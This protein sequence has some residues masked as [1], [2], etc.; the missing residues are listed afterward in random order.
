MKRRIALWELALAV[1]LGSIV[2][3]GFGAD[4]SGVK[5]SVISLPSGPGS[6]EGLG[7]SFEPQL[8]SG[9]SSYSV[10]LATLPGRAGFAP[11]L[12]LTYSSGGTAGVVGLGWSLSLPSL[13][14][15]TDKGMPFYV[16][17]A[18][19]T[20]DDQD[21]TVDEFDELDTIIHSSGE[22]LVPLVDGSWRNENEQEFQR[23]ERVGAGWRSLRKDGVALSFGTTAASRIERPSLGGSY[24]WL[25]DR[26]ED[27]NG[28]VISFVWSGAVDGTRQIYLDAIRYNPNDGSGMV[29]DFEYEARP[30]PISDFRPGFELFTAKRLTRIEMT[31]R[32]NAV[33]AYRLTYAPTSSTQPHSLLA[34]IATEGRD[35]VSTLP[36]AEFTYTEFDSAIG[37]P[38]PMPSAPALAL[39]TDIDLIDLDG[40][41][42]PDILDTGPAVHRYFLNLGADVSGVVAWSPQFFMAASP[43]EKLSSSYVHLADLDGDARTD[44]MRRYD[45]TQ[46][47]QVW[48][49]DAQLKWESNGF[50]TSAGFNLADPDTR[51]VDLDHDK[52]VDVVQTGAT[53]T[54]AWLALPN[55]RYSNPF[56][57]AAGSPALRFSS[58]T[59]HLA[60]MNGDRLQDLV[61]LDSNIV[62]Y[63]PAMGRGRFGPLVTLANPHSGV[64]DPSRLVPVDVNGDGLSDVVW[65]NGGNAI[66]RLNLG[67]T[68][69]AVPTSAALAPPFTISGPVTNGSTQF[70]LADVNANG[71]TDILWNTPGAGSSTF[72]FVDFQ[73]VE[74]PYQLKSITNGIGR[75]TTMVYGTSTTERL[76]DRGTGAPWP[77]PTPSPVPVV[78]RIEV[79]DGRE[80]VVYA[81][82]LD[83]HNGYFDG[84][85]REFRGFS[86]AERK[87]LGDVAQGAPTLVT[88]YQFDL[89][90]T[91][92]S[93]KGKPLQVE[94]RDEAGAVFHRELQTWVV[95]NLAPDLSTPQSG[96][97]RT[98]DFAFPQLTRR[99]VLERGSGTPVVLLAELDYD[100]FGNQIINAEHG[101]VEDLDNSGTIGD[102]AQDKAAWDDE[103]VTVSTWSAAYATGKAEWILDRLVEQEIR[104]DAGVVFARERHFYDDEAFAG[105]NLGDVSN[106]NR[107]MTRAWHD[108]ADAAAFVTSSR[109]AFDAFGNPTHLYDPLWG[110]A[111]GHYR[112]IVYDATFQTFPVE[113]RI[114]TGNPDA[115]GDVLVLAVQ[116]DE[117]FGVVTSA[118]DFNGFGTTYGYDTHGRLTSIVKPGDSVAFP[119]VEYSFVLATDVGSGALI[120]WVETR[121]RETAGGGTVDSRSFYDGLGRKVMT[122][123]E[124]EDPGQIVVSD[125]VQFNARQKESKKYLPYFEIGTLAFVEPSF[126]TGFSRHDYDQLGREIRAT[127]P[128]GP[129]ETPPV[130]SR[131]TYEPL[132]RIV[133][134]EEQTRAGSPHAGANMIYVHDGLMNDESQGR[135]REVHEVVKLTDDGNV[136]PLTTW[137]TQYRYDVLDN[138][139][140]YTDSQNNKKHIFYDGLK[141]KIFMNDPDRSWMWY[142]YDDA[143]NLLRTRDARGHEVAYAYDGVNRLLSEHYASASENAGNALAYAQRWTSPGAPPNRPGDVAYHYDVIAGPVETGYN[144]RPRTTPEILVD[145]ILGR[146]LIQPG[147]DLTGDAS[148]NA[149][150][151][152]RSV[153]LVTKR[154]EDKKG[155]P[156]IPYEV[157]TARNVRGYLAWVRDLS[158]AEHSSRDERGRVEWTAKAIRTSSGET[159]TL[160]TLRTFDSMDRITRLTYPDT[161]WIDYSYNFRGALES[162]P[163]IVT[164][165][166]RNPAGQLARFDYQVGTTTVHGFDHRLRLNRI[167]TL[168]VADLVS[169]Q[170]LAYD[171]DGVSNITTITDARSDNHLDS[172][173][174]ELGVGPLVARTFR[175]TQNFTY[176]SLYRVT[177][178]ENANV[179][180][181]VDFRFDR[182][183]NMRQKTGVLIAPDGKSDLGEMV[184]GGSALATGNTAAW[185]RDGRGL[186]ELPGPHTFTASQRGGNGSNPMTAQVDAAGRVVENDGAI[187]NWD[188]LD[189]ISSIETS[190][191][192]TEFKYDY[193]G[194]RRTQ[195][196]GNGGGGSQDVLYISPAAEIRDGT[197]LKYASLGTDRVAVA[198]G[199]HAASL[200]ATSYWLQDH[201]GSLSLALSGAGLVGEQVARHAFGRERIEQ[202]SGGQRSASYRYI[203]KELQEGSRLAYVEQRY[204]DTV[205]GRF[206]STDTKEPLG[207]SP[208]RN[209]L[210][211][212][213]LGSPVR[214]VDLTG[215]EEE[216]SWFSGKFVSNP[217]DRYVETPGVERRMEASKIHS[218]MG[219]LNHVN[220]IAN[221]YAEQQRST[222]FSKQAWDVQQKIRATLKEG[223]LVSVVIVWDKA[224]V[225]QPIVDFFPKD[226]PNLIDYKANKFTGERTITTTTMTVYKPISGAGLL[227][228][229]AENMLKQHLHRNNL[230]RT[231]ITEVMPPGQDHRI[232]GGAFVPVDKDDAAGKLK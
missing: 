65:I 177:S 184:Y 85:E 98:V 133:E 119:T 191:I 77:D 165:I 103:R 74:Q 222:N 144:P 160:R 146:E 185:N 41:A 18:N 174:A 40:D 32:G 91:Q 70:R 207:A 64:A 31:E 213:S 63:R 196:V 99:E 114:H 104:D 110:T 45:A 188:H 118:T 92:E 216:P 68:N 4:K 163:G 142:A 21:G 8:N 159:P 168:R 181:K 14:R 127:Q 71:S 9:T 73:P 166:D 19:G 59:T 190:G 122:R 123:A 131:I 37:A 149:L 51:L 183:G 48:H 13:Q 33:R 84:L 80:Q 154:L 78:K 180:G 17:A 147:F 232:E 143:S 34:S 97:S 220:D 182:I 200:Q 36:P 105:V 29:I 96:D 6:I 158:G 27:T 58:P 151:V 167:H 215:N 117:G 120:N 24:R 132:K 231:S 47:V 93:L 1:L 145:S 7:E 81:T 52:R 22:E 198:D 86:R 176:D 28:N 124:G 136:G 173:G 79:E 224:S 138:F 226:K 169:L 156:L 209:H 2:T 211:L 210:Y 227:N 139:L 214:N 113:E 193:L 195:A 67:I 72:A 204:L 189:R 57:L 157:V 69:A 95:S 87:E 212:Y 152:S 109:T 3:P 162:I 82:E 35:G 90:L 56:V 50:L 94:A 83:Y 170:D 112:E 175:E 89:G 202:K 16:D 225:D 54:T 135:L 223:E 218:G 121:Q 49:L 23:F 100:N 194:V 101:R 140:G 192:T 208:Q 75:T 128:E 187:I 219:I 125:T 171:F 134:D 66:V 12:A 11:E 115:P 230:S 15:Q 107:T 179:W 150:D 88:A 106:G 141:R 197:L 137:V 61:R 108:P 126:G 111:P 229:P 30:D 25:L 161:S 38:S 5:P 186:S 44:L 206:L 60:D 102:S 43:A 62:E 155:S 55:G 153:D 228:G 221:Q 199:F 178:A 10:P 148:V 130:F 76:R 203:G 205:T 20:D 129:G 46:I 53:L 39:G 42:L 172:I 26:M 116:Y 201:S 164:R 217:E